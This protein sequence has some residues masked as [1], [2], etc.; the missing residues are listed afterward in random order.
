MTDTAQ[1]IVVAPIEEEMKRSYIDY[2]M[3]VIVSR[4]LPDV[5]DG[6]K[7]VQRRII[8]SMHELGVRHDKPH[9]KCARLVGEAM[10]KYHPHGD[11]AIY[12]ALAR[13][14]QPFNMRYPLVDGHGNFGSVDGDPPAAMR[15]TEARLTAMAEELLVD[16]DKETVDFVPNFDDTLKE[17]A[18]LPSRIPNLLV[19]GSAGIAVGMATNIPPHN[20]SET[21]DA[22]VALIDNPD[23]SSLELMKHIKGPDFPTGGLIVGLE[24][25]RS[26][27]TT[28]R[29]IMKVRAKARIENDKTGKQFII[30]DELPYQVNKAKL[31]EN[32]ADLVREKKIQGIGDLRDE[33]DKSG[34]RIVVEVRKDVDA[35]VV[36][37][38]LFKHTSME[39]SFGGIMLALVNGR[40]EVLTLR[41]MLFHY[42]SHR[43]EVVTRRTRYEL[44]KAEERAH[45]LAGLEIALAN[46]DEVIAII[47]QSADGQQARERLM[48]RF[49]LDEIQARAILD[50][51]LERLTSLERDKIIEERRTLLKEIEYLRAVLTSEKMILGIVKQELEE[52]KEKYGDRR[53]TRILAKAE[54]IQ[55]EDLI[56]EQE[57]SVILTGMGYIK[58]MPLDIYRNQRRG[59]FGSTAM[60]TR[61]EDWVEKV[62]STT[63]RD[64]LLLFTSHGK[65]YSLRVFD[66]PEAGRQAK[67]HLVSRLVALDKDEKVTA[68]IPVPSDPED[69]GDL[70]FVTKY[71]MCKRTPFSEYSRPRKTGLKAINL[72]KGD[73]LILAR[74]VEDGDQI[75]IGT[76]MGKGLRMQVDDVRSMG[77]TATG[78]I[79]IRLEKDDCVVGADPVAPDSNVLLVSEFGYGKITKASDFPL[80]KRGGKGVT[81]LKVTE[82]SGRLAIMR[83]VSSKAEEAL[84]VTAEGVAIRIKLSEV[85]ISRRA[86]L[87]VRLM[88]I[89][90]ED[91]LSAC[92]IIEG[93]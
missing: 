25:V 67:G 80:Q 79:G 47:R 74:L 33:S 36:L 38:Q 37:N 52:V 77:R 11:Q 18:V 73:S 70:F 19:N 40:P 1:K 42:I 69:A 15:Y 31:I 20:L 72:K 59:G 48:D 35:K 24:P 51:R 82:K 86:N 81:A 78:V 71:G 41:D 91:R 58:R 4:A 85:K 2:S 29:G 55:D 90:P 68:L 88:K 13:M 23:L 44:R 12:D 83:V 6:L 49:N 63:T 56:V 65:A 3:S 32:I 46:L 76:S 60:Q 53:R 17:P 64:S 21:I 28:G 87:G 57:V 22:L 14:A 10:G 75:L 5:R 50:M 54:E 93:E 45:I 39:V 61:D 84:L 27:Y 7:P 8:Y 92:S 89:E 9:K 66:I 43:E 16:L 34:L 62:V 30:V 26:L